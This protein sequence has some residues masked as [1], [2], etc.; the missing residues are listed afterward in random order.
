[1]AE[2]KALVFTIQIET[3]SKNLI[4]EEELEG[5]YHVGQY[6]QA[7]IETEWTPSVVTSVQSSDPAQYGIV[8]IKKNKTFFL[9]AE[10]LR[11]PPERLLVL[12]DDSM[13]D[14]HSGE[15]LELAEQVNFSLVSS[16][17]ETLFITPSNIVERS[18]S[19]SSQE[20]SLVDF[21][22]DTEKFLTL[23]SPTRVD[24]AVNGCQVEGS[25][26]PVS[27]KHFPVNVDNDG[28][29][30]AEECDKGPDIEVDVDLFH[31]LLDTEFEDD[32]QD[33]NPPSPCPDLQ[34]KASVRFAEVEEGELEDL[35]RAAKSERTHKQTGW[36][37]RILQG[38]YSNLFI[39]YSNCFIPFFSVIVCDYLI[40]K[41]GS[42]RHGHSVSSALA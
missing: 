4:M 27:Q 30:G 20:D 18:P 34:N 33:V 31:E 8:S 5:N 10:S 40:N 24:G 42:R 6:V 35:Q 3:T 11:C 17:D 1:M 21:A 19:H 23:S 26:L 14:S 25:P 38:I 7:Y 28:L 13:D 36:G 37:V 22:L 32:G 16:D 2:K 29:S 12:A 39:P 15:G 9:T 41:V